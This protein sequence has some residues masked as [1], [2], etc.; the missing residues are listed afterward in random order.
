MG[1][2][3]Q[4]SRERF[5]QASVSEENRLIVVAPDN[6]LAITKGN[7]RRVHVFPN[8]CEL[9]SNFFQARLF[10]FFRDN[11]GNFVRCRLSE[12]RPTMLF[13]HRAHNMGGESEYPVFVQFGITFSFPRA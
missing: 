9:F 7:E 1:H 6:N 12:Y 4:P 8:D 2:P 10:V 11:D 13:C 3:V 5:P